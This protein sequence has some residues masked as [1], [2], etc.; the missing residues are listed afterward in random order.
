M[1]DAISVST[2]TAETPQNL[3]SRFYSDLTFGIV[4]VNNHAGGVLSSHTENPLHTPSDHPRLTE[5]E[6][7][8]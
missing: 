1:K 7:A 2:S 5:P 4:L 6:Q 3:I 8:V